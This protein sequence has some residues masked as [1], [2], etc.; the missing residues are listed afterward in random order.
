MTPEQDEAV[1]LALV[2]LLHRAR[3]EELSQLRGI[4]T[5]MYSISPD[6]PRVAVQNKLY[7][8]GIERINGRYSSKIDYLERVFK[9]P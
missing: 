1:A 3:L 9:L 4:L 8:E 5:P 7:Q 2:T 6:D